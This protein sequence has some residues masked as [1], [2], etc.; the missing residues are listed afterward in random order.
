MIRCYM[1]LNNLNMKKLNLGC[2]TDYLKGW[3][4]LD[5]AHGKDIY[6]HHIK[7]DVVWDLNKYPYPFKDNEFDAVRAFAIIEHLN[8]PI[9]T[10][11]EI[12]RIT[13]NNGI[14]GI[15]VPHF[16]NYRNY[17]D[18]THKWFYSVQMAK[19]PLFNQGMQLVK[20]KIIY[21]EKNKLMKVF[22][23]LPNISHKIYEKYFAWIFPSNLIYWR[24]RVTKNVKE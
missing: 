11:E 10:M 23:F 19:N 2:S 16:S 15:I 7:A 14:M 6:G 13:K 20:S 8:S 3:V 18:P 1:G 4:N 22:N 12:K 5:I 9:K 17:S 24:F 21:S